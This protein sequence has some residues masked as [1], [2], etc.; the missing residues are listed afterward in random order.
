M[1]IIEDMSLDELA[2]LEAA[3]RALTKARR[4]KRFDP[5]TFKA[6]ADFELNEIR[7]TLLTE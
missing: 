4:E 5:N 1:G 6:F 2:V 7:E 3:Q